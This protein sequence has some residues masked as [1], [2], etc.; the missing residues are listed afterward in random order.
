MSEQK[1]IKIK[2]RF[3]YEGVELALFLGESE[4]ICRYGEIAEFYGELMQNAYKWFCERKY[5]EIVEE[6]KSCDDPQKKFGRAVRYG[7]IM[8]VF[9]SEE[10]EKS[11]TVTCEVC[12]KNAKDEK[13][14][15]FCDTQTWDKELSI[16]VKKKKEKKK[17]GA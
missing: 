4:G 15:E 8:K 2:N 1:E 6:Y 13:I 5:P 7:Y 10:N 11:V 3:F 16:M 14:S 12:L 9:V 17:K